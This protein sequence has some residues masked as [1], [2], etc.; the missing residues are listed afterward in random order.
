MLLNMN[1]AVFASKMNDFDSTHTAEDNATETNVSSDTFDSLP[2]SMQMEIENAEGTLVSVSTSY[3][4][5]DSGMETRAVMPESDFKLTVTVSRLSD[6][7]MMTDGVEGDAFLFV[8]TGEWLVNPFYEFTDCI[9][10]TWSD[11]FTLYFDNGYIYTEDY[12]GTGLPKFD[13][14]AMTLGEVAAEQGLAYEAD[15]ALLERQN[16]VT[17]VAKVYKPDSSGSAN[18]CASYGHVIK[19]PGDF[20]VTFTAGRKIDISVSGI[21]TDIEMAVPDYKSFNY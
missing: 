19:M 15:L 5:L 3:Y 9:G 16:E 18:V 17:L 21:A 1:T 11:D 8:A 4:D 20:S 6:A 12:Q 2:K 13:Y 7:I 10:I 14:D